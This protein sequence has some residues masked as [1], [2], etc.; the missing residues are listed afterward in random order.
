MN[1]FTLTL[2]QSEFESALANAKAA[3]IELN[4]SGGTLPEADGVAAH[5]T[6]ETQTASYVV[7]VIVD[8]KPFFVSIGLIESH[9]KQLL[10]VA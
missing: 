5:Y 3:G 6:V 8:K 4:P 1:S 2:T 9:V 7:T 10:G